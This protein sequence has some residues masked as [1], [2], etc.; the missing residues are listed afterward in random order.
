MKSSFMLINNKLMANTFSIWLKKYRQESGLTLAQLRGAID[1][2]CSD[3]YLSKL[4]NDRYRGKK[5]N[6]AQP[7]IEIVEALAKALNRPIDEARLAAGYAPTEQHQILP[8][9]LRHIDFSLFNENELI[10]IRNFIEYV[11]F[12]KLREKSTTPAS[13][14]HAPGTR[15]AVSDF[16]ENRDKAERTRARKKAG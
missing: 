12:V 14:V 8:S 2:L 15:R 13:P 3:A 1:N 10:E 5:G 4:E 16:L 6:P 7:D 9:Q 11:L